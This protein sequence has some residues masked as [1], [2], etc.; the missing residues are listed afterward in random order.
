[1]T[2]ENLKQAI[3]TVMIGVTVAFF[4]SLFDA[5]ADFLRAHSQEIV[6]GGLSASLYAIKNIR[7]A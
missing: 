3:I 7:L 1:M 6:S 4:T 2:Q 5:L